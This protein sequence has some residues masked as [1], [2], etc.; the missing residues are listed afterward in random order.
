MRHQKDSAKIFDF[1]IFATQ[2]PTL[3]VNSGPT[4]WSGIFCQLRPVG[5]HSQW[6][7]VVGPIVWL[8]HN[9]FSLPECHCSRNPI[10]FPDALPYFNMPLEKGNILWY[11]GHASELWVHQLHH[12]IEATLPQKWWCSSL[13]LGCPCTGSGTPWAWSCKCIPHQVGLLCFM[14]LMRAR[15]DVSSLPFNLA[16]SCQAGDLPHD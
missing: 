2:Y 8:Y 16:I 9:C 4:I 11:C 3:V 12:S 10:S 15:F 7:W 6:S 5:I 1:H 14:V 13:S